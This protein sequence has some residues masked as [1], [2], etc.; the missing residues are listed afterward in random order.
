MRGFGGGVIATGAA[1]EG[2]IEADTSSVRSLCR[3]AVQMT[4]GAAG[5]SRARLRS[6]YVSQSG[7]NDERSGWGG[8]READ[9]QSSRELWCNRP[10]LTGGAASPHMA[11]KSPGVPGVC[12]PLSSEKEALSVQEGSGAAGARG[13]R[14]CRGR[15]DGR[16]PVERFGGSAARASRRGHR[17]RSPVGG[18]FSPGRGRPG[19]ELSALVA[20]GAN[21]SH[22]TGGEVRSGQ[23]SQSAMAG[24]ADK[25]DVGTV[26]PPRRQARSPRAAQEARS[27]ER[28]VVDVGGARGGVHELRQAAHEP[29]G[30]LPPPDETDPLSRVCPGGVHLGDVPAGAQAAHGGQLTDGRR[31]PLRGPAASASARGPA[32]RGR[33]GSRVGR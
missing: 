19:G 21:R 2:R 20:Q 14:R 24:L 23:K 6:L 25:R 26:D 28:M 11:H 32:Q 1:E 12:L 31:C 30:R 10:A 9:A 29:E 5:I 3:R 13:L 22:A 4:N 27:P 18:R 15:A 8:R 17:R 7:T 33:R 16:F